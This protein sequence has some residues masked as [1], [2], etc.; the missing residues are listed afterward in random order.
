M[1]C[2]V[3]RSEAVAHAADYFDSGALLADLGRCQL[4]FAVGTDIAGMRAPGDVLNGGCARGTMP[5]RRFVTS[6]QWNNA[7]LR[8]TLG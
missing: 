1:I 5:G 4:R 3:A 8:F 6:G 7:R 2:S